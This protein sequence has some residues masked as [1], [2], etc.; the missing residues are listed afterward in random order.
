M[1][2]AFGSVT[3]SEVQVKAR[4]GQS[5][6]FGMVEMPDGREAEAAIA[7]PEQQRA[8]GAGP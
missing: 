6:G 5:R 3:M 7:A 1:F 2:E 4:T 8:P